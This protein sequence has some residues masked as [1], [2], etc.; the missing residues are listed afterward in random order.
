M[1]REMRG[2]M[3]IFKI[4][5]VLGLAVLVT[6]CGNTRTGSEDL[7]TN[8]W[9]TVS[10]AGNN[11]YST[12]ATNC[13]GNPNITSPQQGY[14][15]AYSYHA[16]KTNGSLSIY[17]ADSSTR[18]VCVFPVQVINGS[19]YPFVMNPNAPVASR[20]AYQCANVSQN[21]GSVNFGTMQVNGVYIVDQASAPNFALCM[22]YGDTRTCAAAAGFAYSAGS[23]Q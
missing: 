14:G 2:I 22:S 15:N 12:A 4:V 13:S 11:P 5:S 23:V 16:C 21:G 9:N 17:T 10:P 3:K 18:N 8:S 6:A 19:A 20:Y 1:V 7:R